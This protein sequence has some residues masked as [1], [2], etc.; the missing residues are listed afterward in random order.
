MSRKIRLNRFFLLCVCV[1]SAILVEGQNAYLEKKVNLPVG[2]GMLKTVL[3]SIST[4]TGCIF[5]YD[6]TKIM[7][8]QVVTVS[9]KGSVSLHAALSE[10]LPKNILYKL[11]GKYIVL[12]VVESKAAVTVKTPAAIPQKLIKPIVQPKK[13]RG[14]IDKD[15]ALERLVLPPIEPAAEVLPV[16]AVIDTV[17]V[18]P[19]D[20]VRLTQNTIPEQKADST[21]RIPVAT[22]TVPG[23]PIVPS[24]LSGTDTMKVATAGF[25]NFINKKGYL[26]MALSLSK[27]LGSLSIRPGLYNVYAIL[28]IGSDYNKSYLLGFGAGI[29]VRI[30]NHYSLNFD[31]LR[32]VIIAGKTYLLQV[33]ASNTQILP[34]LNYSLGNVFK[35]FAGPTVN[36]INSSYINSVS[37]TNLGALVGI[38]FSMGIKVDLKSLWTKQI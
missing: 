21:L 35:V 4:Q 34:M 3:K 26:E 23:Y 12:Q 33:R 8:K 18:L 14:T 28:S 2:P 31:L 36:L 22:D 15:L 30:D 32:N 24:N 5:S 19:V 29:H 9:T 13:G 7:D 1:F 16:P 38:G 6:P 27:Q 10:I 17:P 20:S 25:G 11:N 37:T